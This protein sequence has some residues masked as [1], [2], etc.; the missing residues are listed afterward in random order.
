MLQVVEQL[1]YLFFPCKL[2]GLPLLSFFVCYDIDGRP[3]ATTT[4]MGLD[5]TS[6]PRYGKKRY[7]GRTL[8]AVGTT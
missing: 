2:V 8:Q 5:A 6:P 7:S 1:D 4:M 3:K